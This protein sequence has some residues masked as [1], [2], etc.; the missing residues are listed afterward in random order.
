MHVSLLISEV[1]HR[2]VSVRHSVG[3]LHQ[4]YQFYFYSLQLERAYYQTRA[5]IGI[6]ITIITEVIACTYSRAL[7]IHVHPP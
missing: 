7:P 6:L 5:I 2:D 1:D 3:T 4:L